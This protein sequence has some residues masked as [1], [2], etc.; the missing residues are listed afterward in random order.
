[1]VDRLAPS[2]FSS[3]Y[4]LPTK[5]S[6]VILQSLIWRLQIVTLCFCL[7]SL[8]KDGKIG[9][10]NSERLKTE[11]GEGKNITGYVYMPDPKEPG[12]LIVHLEGTPFDAPCK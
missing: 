10:L 12:K 3:G 4:L 7:D 2:L 5:N 1:M 6:I 11:T 9:V 8:R